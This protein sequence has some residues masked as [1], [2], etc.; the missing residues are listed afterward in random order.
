VGKGGP[1]GWPPPAFAHRSPTPPPAHRRAISGLSDCNGATSS[2]GWEFVAEGQF[3]TP[4]S[5]A[6]PATFAA[7]GAFLKYVVGPGVLQDQ[8]GLRIATE[9]RPLLPGQWRLGNRL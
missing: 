1:G 7:T 5:P 9:F 2:E 8:A 6:G 3:E 4:L